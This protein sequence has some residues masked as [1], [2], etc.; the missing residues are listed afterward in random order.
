MTV[1]NIDSESRDI[2]GEG[3]YSYGIHHLVNEERCAGRK[4]RPP[5]CSMKNPNMGL[6]TASG[7][8]KNEHV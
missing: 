5:T 8:R 1:H 4:K 7:C 2:H 6:K 3:E